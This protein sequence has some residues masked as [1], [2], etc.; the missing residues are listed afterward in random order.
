MSLDQL[1]VT[2]LGILVDNAGRNLE[3]RFTRDTPI[4]D[5]RYLPTAGEA[6]GVNAL[7]VVVGETFHWQ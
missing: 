6:A 2:T 3:S 7:G 4:T 1:W 5:G